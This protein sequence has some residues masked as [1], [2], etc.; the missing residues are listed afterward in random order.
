MRNKN[1][2][3]E[4]IKQRT[5]ERRRRK[6]KVFEPA[7]II[8]VGELFVCMVRVS[9]LSPS[10]AVP[11]VPMTDTGI[12]TFSL[13]VRLVVDGKTTT[14]MRDEFLLDFGVIVQFVFNDGSGI[15]T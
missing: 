12:K 8:V 11:S 3:E 2:V 10:R 13:F 7:C 1:S 15:L 5:A 14:K 6:R 4:K 9:S